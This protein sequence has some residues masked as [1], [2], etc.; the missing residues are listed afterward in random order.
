MND[1]VLEGNGWLRIMIVR[2]CDMAHSF[3]LQ[4]DELMAPWRM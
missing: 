2:L 3:V 4:N 1:E